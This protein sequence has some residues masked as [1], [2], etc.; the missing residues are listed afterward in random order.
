MCIDKFKATI[1]YNDDIKNLRKA[2]PWRHTLCDTRVTKERA[3]KQ[4]YLSSIVAVFIVLLLLLLLL[5]QLFVLVLLFI[6]MAPTRRQMVKWYVV[7]LST[8]NI[9]LVVDVI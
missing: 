8:V 3:L 2:P 1:S 9:S 6:W 7:L 4:L 5:K